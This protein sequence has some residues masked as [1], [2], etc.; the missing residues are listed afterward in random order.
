MYRKGL[1]NKYCT[2]QEVLVQ[3]STTL[4]RSAACSACVCAVRR[5]DAHERFVCCLDFCVAFCHRDIGMSGTAEKLAANTIAAARRGQLVRM[6]LRTAFNAA[7]RIIAAHRGREARAFFSEARG[8]ESRI[9]AD[10]RGKFARTMLGD[11]KFSACILEAY[12]RG[13]LA[14]KYFSAQKKVAI[15]LQ[16]YYRGREGR[17]IAAEKGWYRDEQRKY[18]AALAVVQYLLSKPEGPAT[19]PAIA[20]KILSEDFVDTIDLG[21]GRR[22]TRK[23]AKDFLSNAMMNPEAPQPES[24]LVALWATGSKYVGD[25]EVTRV[26][27]EVLLHGQHLRVEYTVRHRVGGHRI[28]NRRTTLVDKLEDKSLEDDDEYAPNV[29]VVRPPTLREGL[30]KLDEDG[31]GSLSVDEIVSATSLVG[32]HLEP[33]EL[34]QQLAVGTGVFRIHELDTVLNKDK[35]LQKIGLSP[36]T[37]PLLFEVLPLVA[38]TYDA[39]KTVSAC[40]SRAK[41]REEELA[42]EA[43]ELVSAALRP[44]AAMAEV[45]RA[46][47]DISSDERRRGIELPKAVDQMNSAVQ[48]SASKLAH[49]IDE[50]ELLASVEGA[51]ATVNTMYEAL[52]AACIEWS[53]QRKKLKPIMHAATRQAI[54]FSKGYSPSS[55]RQLGQRLRKAHERPPN[56]S[57][58]RL[59][60]VI[61]SHG[62][63]PNT[64]AGDIQ[65]D[66]DRRPRASRQRL[67]KS[68]SE[69][70][71]RKLAL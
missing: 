53:Q 10:A 22:E 21:P 51:S 64:A 47:R 27:R 6:H 24:V 3:Y 59:P 28:C 48:R 52:D 14:R 20:D 30:A 7:S 13:Y 32:L 66:D 56:R 49:L 25:H 55:E 60:P 23:G 5:P 11:A 8:A 70:V 18:D 29:P 9:A 54:A 65:G 50:F 37:R 17:K 36:S 67:P 40:I 33:E 71:V 16:R 2:V 69:P 1:R 39:H 15:N 68:R 58:V 4:V 61:T 19:A 41:E 63:M 12:G 45:R 62:S 46:A 43:R 42:R 34:Q 26:E 38:T 31:S 44:S 57:R 35:R